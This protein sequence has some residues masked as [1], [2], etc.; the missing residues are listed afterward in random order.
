MSLDGLLVLDLSRLLPGGYCTQ[1]LLAQGANVTKVEPPAGDPI[2]ALPGGE[3]YFEAL[4]HGKQVVTLDLRAQ[5]GRDALRQRVVDADVLV[6]GF[7]PGVMERMDLGYAALAAINPA[8]VYCAITGYGSSGGMAPRAGHDLN[9]LARSGALSLM[10]LR[11][12]LPAI[13]GLQVADLAGG[14]EAAFLIAAALTSREKSGRGQRVEVSM[15]DLIRSW[16]AL[17]RAARL[18]GL[19]GLLLTGELPCY[20]VYAVAD[21]FLTVAALETA[22]W[23]EFCHAINREDLK[24]RQFDPG[25]IDSVQATLGEATRAEWA[26]RFGERDVCVEPVLS[27]EETS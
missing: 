18:A 16:T 23:A 12:G 25:A 15:T 8:L 19:P 17:P 13:P 9:Y 5:S 6:E 11:D 14:L 7:R 26:A 1:L 3:A 20:H 10:P 27:L 4:H 24:D 22:F 2:R 21:G